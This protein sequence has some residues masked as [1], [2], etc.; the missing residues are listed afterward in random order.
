[1]LQNCMNSLM[2][3]MQWAIK[4]LNLGKGDVEVKQANFA[5]LA[6][7]LMKVTSGHSLHTNTL[8]IARTISLV[9]LLL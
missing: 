4:Y 9:F 1:M 6:M 7:R 3:S 8:Y 5:A 2:S